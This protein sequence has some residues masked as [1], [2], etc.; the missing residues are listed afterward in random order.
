MNTFLVAYDFREFH[1]KSELNIDFLDMSEIAQNSQR[2]IILGVNLYFVRS[3]GTHTPITIHKQI[4]TLQNQ[5]RPASVH[6]LLPWEQ[7]MGT[8]LPLK[9]LIAKKLRK[10]NNISKQSKPAWIP[11]IP[12]RE[13][14]IP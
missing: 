13:G 2:L 5:S 8:K 12:L 4:Q 6:L 10:P 11:G 14:L 7:Q 1:K 3:R 9:L